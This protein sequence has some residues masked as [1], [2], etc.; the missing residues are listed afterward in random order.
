MEIILYYECECVLRDEYIETCL[1]GC[2]RVYTSGYLWGDVGGG[3]TKGLYIHIYLWR[4][5]IYYVNFSLF[6]IGSATYAHMH[7]V[8]FF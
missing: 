5:E 4:C 6:F 3:L 7:V 8:L 2:E 1:D